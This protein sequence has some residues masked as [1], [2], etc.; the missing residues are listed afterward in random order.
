VGST[1]VLSKQDGNNDSPA[2]S[3]RIFSGVF[4]SL[5]KAAKLDIAAT[6]QKLC[7][8]DAQSCQVFCSET[9]FGRCAL[10]RRPICRV[11][12]RCGAAMTR[13][14]EAAREEPIVMR[15]PGEAQVLTPPAYRR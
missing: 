6:L 3:I 9:S 15:C 8:G 12:Y 10:G 11:T 2:Q 4:G 14:V 1:S 13:S 5:G 7:G